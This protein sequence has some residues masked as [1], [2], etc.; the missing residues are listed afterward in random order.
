MLS[1]KIL[2]MCVRSANPKVS[3][4]VDKRHSR[5]ESAR[6]FQPFSWRL[7][8]CSWFIFRFVSCMEKNRVNLEFYGKK[9]QSSSKQLGIF[10][11]RT[12]VNENW[13]GCWHFQVSFM[14]Q[15]LW[16]RRAPGEA[17]ERRDAT[18]L[19]NK[20]K[21]RS[22]YLFEE[23]TFHF[24]NLEE[25]REVI[26]SVVI[27]CRG[28]L[29]CGFVVPFYGVSV[30]TSVTTNSHCAYNCKDTKLGIIQDFLQNM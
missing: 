18:I 13:K 25:D 16:G 21:V 24:W 26:L 29:K 3:P 23:I 8:K 19:K 11:F 27:N 5:T 14:F 30:W 7:D 17:E 6:H 20:K 15:N 12:H 2:T 10:N 28:H 22:F 4:G 1:T 9:E